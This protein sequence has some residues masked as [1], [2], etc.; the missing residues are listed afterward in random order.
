[1]KEIKVGKLVCIW[2]GINIIISIFMA[3]YFDGKAERTLVSVIIKS[4]ILLVLLMVG[5]INKK[6]VFERIEDFKKKFKFKEIIVIV[7]MQ[8][9]I[10]RCFE[11][12]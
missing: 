11:R 12:I 4:I 6:I 8:I 1:M 3:D 9:L 10:S 2:I 7:I 5:R